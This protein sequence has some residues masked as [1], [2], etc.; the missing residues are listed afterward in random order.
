MDGTGLAA[1]EERLVG[2]R[3]RAGA[4]M[5]GN[6][7]QSPR[8]VPWL[9]LALVGAPFWA[10]AGP[11]AAQEQPEENVGRALLEPVGFVDGNLDGVND[12]FADADGDGRDDVTGLPYAHGFPFSDR[13]GDGRNDFFVDADGDGENDLAASLREAGRTDAFAV[14]DANADG[15]N[16]VLGVCERTGDELGFFIESTGR[17]V[18][19][20]DE[21]GDGL[22]DLNRQRQMQPRRVRFVDRDGDGIQDGRMLHRQGEGGRGKAGGSR[23]RHGHD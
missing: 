23:G 13:D 9:W 16:D 2:P 7:R 19:F 15:V 20:V 1:L 22:N 11:V 12:F 4:T 10:G 18:S 17:R 5:S 8:W 21:D 6:S 3:E 14:I